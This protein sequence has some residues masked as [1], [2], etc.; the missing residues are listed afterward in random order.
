M[1]NIRSYYVRGK[2]VMMVNYCSR[3]DDFHKVDV[4]VDRSYN[5]SD[6]NVI[7]SPTFSTGYARN[8]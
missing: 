1:Y 8:F 6:K 2:P 7:L 3:N 5:I 4:L